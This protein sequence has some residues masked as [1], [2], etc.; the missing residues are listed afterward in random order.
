[1]ATSTQFAD[2]QSSAIFL[3]RLFS[4]VFFSCKKD[5]IEKKNKK[6][7][8]SSTRTDPSVWKM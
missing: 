3:Y 7:H 2:M 8:G 1:M 6:K 4:F 5:N